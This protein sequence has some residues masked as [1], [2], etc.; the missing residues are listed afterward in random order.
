MSLLSVPVIVTLGVLMQGLVS[1]APPLLK[2]DASEMPPLQ[3][4]V[5][6]QPSVH[7]G[8]A[9]FRTLFCELAARERPALDCERLLVRLAAEP[10]AA[11]SAPLPQHDPRLRILLVPGGFAE[12]FKEAGLF[13]EALP[14]LQAAG[15]SVST[16]PVS[17]RSSSAYNAWRIA[18][19]VARTSLPPDGLLVLAGYSKGVVDILEFLVQY[20][21][22]AARVHAV[23]SVSGSVN[24][25]PIAN[26]YTFLF[27]ATDDLLL[28]DCPPGDRGVAEDLKRE[29]RMNWLARHRLPGHIRYF[30]IATVAPEEE[31]AR[32]MA[33]TDGPLRYVDPLSDGQLIFYDQLLPGSE[34]LGYV[35]ADHWAV[36]LPLQKHW[37]LLASNPAGTHFPRGLLLE[38]IMLHLSEALRDNT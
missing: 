8:R 14:R 29:P 10:P 28:R 37:Y 27:E 31:V 3:L 5:V 38:A 23:V 35:R 34:L 11:A 24:G 26:R 30:S 9:R 4:A 25:S 36:A 7:D 13:P 33:L 22:L 20:P 17:G 15:Y 21:S 16:V 2:Y 12:C 32:A 18:V 19:A 6:G 1:C